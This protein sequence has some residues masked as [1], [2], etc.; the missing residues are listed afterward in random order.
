M[1]AELLVHGKTVLFVSEKMAALEVVKQRL[2]GVGLGEFCLELHSRKSR[3]RDVLAELER[4]LGRHEP[5]ERARSL[6]KRKDLVYNIEKLDA[7]VQDLS[8]PFGQ[9]RFS[10]YRLYGMKEEAILHFSESGREVP[11]FEIDDDGD[12]TI[13]RLTQVPRVLYELAGLLREVGNPQDHPWREC[14]PDILLPKHI[15][16]ISQRVK[17]AF[18]LI[19]RIRPLGE[20]LSH[21]LGTSHFHCFQNV[22]NVRVCAELLR[23]SQHLPAVGVLSPAWFDDEPSNIGRAAQLVE[24]LQ[25]SRT[26]LGVVFAEEAFEANADVLLLRLRKTRE[27]LIPFLNR[28]YRACVREIALLYQNPP[29]FFHRIYDDDLISLAKYQVEQHELAGLNSGYQ[30]HFGHIWRGEESDVEQLREASAWVK[31]FHTLLGDGVCLEE[32]A[33]IAEQGLED[34]ANLFLKVKELEDLATQA[35]SAL[36]SL[37]SILQFDPVVTL[38]K[39]ADAASLQELLQLLER[40]RQNTDKLSLWAHYQSR[41]R[42][43]DLLPVQELIKLMEGRVVDESDIEPCLN[44]SIAEK[45]LRRVFAERENL[46]R[47]VRGVQESRVRKFQELDKEVIEASRREVYQKLADQRPSLVGGVAR[48]SEAGILLREVNKKKR[49]MPIRKLMEQ[50]GGLI[51]K[52]KPCFMM[53]PLSIAQFLDP[54]CTPFDVVIFDEASQVRPQDALGALLRGRQLV[55]MGDTKQLPPTSFFDHL[56]EDTDDEDADSVED[57]GSMLHLCRTSFPVRKLRWHYRSRHESLIAVSNSEFYDNQLVV[58]PSPMQNDPHLG[59]LFVHLPDT[60]YDRGRT[61]ENREEAIAVARAAIQQYKTRPDRSLGVGAFSVK[62]QNAILE[63]VHRELIEHP[64]MECYFSHD[65][66]EHFFVKNLETIQ[67]DERD[68][69][70]LSMGYG[71]DRFRKLSKQFGPLNKDGGERRLNVLITRARY[72]CV[73]FSNFR[74]DDLP[75]DAHASKGVRALK[76][77]LKFAE[78]G[79]LEDI[80]LELR[81][82]DSPF[83]DAVRDFLRCEGFHVEQQVG[84]A[85]YRIDLAVVDP[86]TPGRFVLGIE[87]DGAQYH[88]SRV[89]RERDRLRQQILEGLGWKLYRVWSTDWYTERRSAQDRLLSAVHEAIRTPQPNDVARPSRSVHEQSNRDLGRDVSR[90]QGAS[91]PA[92]KVTDDKSNAIATELPTQPYVKC[93]Q[94]KILM[95]NAI[96]NTPRERLAEAVVSIVVIEAPVHVDE[97]IRRIRTLWG[98]KRSGRLIHEAITRGIR[99][100]DSSKGYPVC[101]RGDF[102]WNSDQQECEIRCRQEKELLKIDLIS[103]EEVGVSV[104]RTLELQFASPQEA[105]STTAARLLGFHQTSEQIRSRIDRVLDE[106]IKQG[107]IRLKDNGMIDLITRE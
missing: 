83:E 101:L 59:L 12:W 49:H 66:D 69:I 60:V 48:D 32:F 96:H 104:L 88:S 36:S 82:T 106:M 35:D 68:V 27:S 22:S 2:D 57:M 98:L 85:D 100:A 42:S 47:F 41:K 33:H 29:P 86:E 95:H 3:K 53:S 94:L 17:T 9:L 46:A 90:Q 65:Q 77:F 5:Q 102:L 10:P 81:D 80:Q 52:I 18:G 8:M 84:C 30:F 23:R 74:S 107:R 105:I 40:W 55:V 79:K 72:Q 37:F 38:G 11:S 25:A 50:A 91:N 21:Q 56:V 44:Y 78:T 7:Y 26:K 15:Q 93:K 89:A 71:F 1:V 16:E 19:E 103:N 58:Y 62:Q 73:V 39:P 31:D 97:V 99:L 54:R 43:E 76:T 20:E 92:S 4:C 34:H 75:I 63:E 45:E 61:A 51:Q 24:S 13:D 6:N 70:F 28:D 87:C 67:G 14:Y 64:E